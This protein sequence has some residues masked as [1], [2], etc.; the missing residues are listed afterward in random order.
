MI[1]TLV[2]PHKADVEVLSR[3]LKLFLAGS[4][5]SDTAERWQDNLIGVLYN[6]YHNDDNVDLLICNPRRPDYDAS[7]SA[8]SSN[9]YFAE[10]VN[11]EM[12]YLEHA[13]VIVFYIDPNTKSAITLLELG[14]HA[15]RGRYDIV[16]YCPESFY[17][18]GNVDIVCERYDIPVNRTLVDFIVRLQN[19]VEG[20]RHAY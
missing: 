10:Q 13:D 18:S 17:R 12:D 1:T 3:K 14:L 5:E 19:L 2:A 4:I 15:F 16:V 8:K 7:Q 11:W 9:P 6:R 20:N